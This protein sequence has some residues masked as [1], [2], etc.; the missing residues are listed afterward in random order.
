[1]TA[2]RADD[3]RARTVFLGS[4]PFGG[5]SLRRLADHDQVDLVGVV[6]A[7]PRPAGRRQE[8]TTT[9]IH[10]L[11]TDLGIPAIL[12]PERLRAAE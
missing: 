10:E 9:P 12:T 4:G 3:S 6:T 1:M 2:W 11:A 8:P 7:P 5:E